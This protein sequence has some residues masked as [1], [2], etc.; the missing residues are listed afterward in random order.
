MPT[1][2]DWV[3]N[4]DG[5]QGE[6]WNPI[7]GCTKVS[8]GCKYCYAESMHRRF[9]KEPFSQ[10]KFHPERLYIPLKNKKMSTMYFVISMG[11]MFHEDV[12]W[13]Q[14]DKIIEVIA[15]CPQH[16]FVVL[17]KRPKNMCIYFSTEE[18]MF[19][20]GHFM[21][22]YPIPNLWLGVSCEDQ[23]TY[24]E[25][26]SI[27]EHIACAKR[28]I[29]FEPLISEIETNFDAHHVKPDWVIVGGE[30]G[31]NGRKMDPSWA[32]EI[33]SQCSNYNI[34]FFFKQ[35]GQWYENNRMTSTD[36][37]D[38]TRQFPEGYMR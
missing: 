2:I 15:M 12:E 5:T 26:Y 22:Q 16:T 18:R 19:K 9:N 17:T 28:V 35:W 7:T 36:P 31:S 33:D 20:K 6:S 13:K 25:R 1:K 14:I 27:L 38:M 4:P 29:S 30:S 24:D 34:P 3:Q 37:R 8:A 32:G 21:G 11:D 23:K 10:I